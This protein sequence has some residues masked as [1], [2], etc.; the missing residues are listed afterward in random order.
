MADTPNQDWKK[1]QGQNPGSGQ[2]QRRNPQNPQTP[3]KADQQDKPG[4]QQGNPGGNKDRN[5]SR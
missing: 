1:N 2:D 5:P 4:T 3:R